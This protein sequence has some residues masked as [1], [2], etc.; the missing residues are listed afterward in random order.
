MFSPHFLWMLKNIEFA[1]EEWLLS[2][3]IATGMENVPI[4]IKGDNTESELEELFSYYE[5][6]S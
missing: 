2:S 4:F 6:Q 3:Y 1:P 5:K